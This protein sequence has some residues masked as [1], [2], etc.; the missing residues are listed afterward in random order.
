MLTRICSVLLVLLFAQPAFAVQADTENNYIRQSVEKIRNGVRIHAGGEPV[1]SVLVLPAL[2]ERRDYVPVWSNPQS[3]NQLFDILG[4]IEADGLDSKDYHLPALQSMRTSLSKDANRDPSRAADYDLLLTDSLIRLGYHLM[5]GKVDPEALD[6]N[7]NMNTTLGDLDTILAMAG[8]IED[9]TL[10]Q[11]V[12]SL[13]LE[14]PTYAR[15]KRALAH[16]RQI[17]EQGGWPSVPDGPTLKPGMSGQRVVAMRKRLVVTGELASDTSLDMFDDQLEAAVKRFQ[18]VNGLAADGVVGPGTLAAMNVPVDARIDQIRVNLE[19]ARWVLHDLSGEYVLVDIAGFR[20]K[21]VRDGKDIWSGR[22]QVGKPYRKTPIFRDSIRY[23]EV[24]P[25][26]TVPPTI[27]KNDVLPKIKK[28]PGY[29]GQKDMQVLTFGGEPVDPLTIDWNLYPD[30]PFSYMIRQRPGPAN[31]LGRIKFMFPNKHAIYLHD[32]P[33]RSLFN[34]DARAFSSGCIRVEHPFE[35]AEKLLDDEAWSR[36]RLLDLVESRKTTRVNLNRPV[37]VL[38]LYW[39]V[40]AD[41][42]GG[43][44]FK[45]DVYDRDPTILRELNSPF[46]FRAGPILDE[47]A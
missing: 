24:N 17:A 1:S 23:L 18:R 7:W 34:R 32:T 41:D 42:D 13:R 38:L 25:T 15:Y 39:T 35:F 37:T 29:L 9:A 47:A 27:L 30:S 40:D 45:Q 46:H 26:W 19:R 3:V 12:D 8:A 6:A 11:L 21:Y 14:H 33:S 20:V 28:D 10:P 44:I 2:Y 43:V 22:A 36:Q 16:Y 31:A 5:A 4:E